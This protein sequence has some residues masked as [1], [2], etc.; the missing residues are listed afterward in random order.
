MLEIAIMIEGQN[1]LTWSRWQKIVHLVEELG[2]RFVSFD[3]FT[4]S[5]ANDL[6]SLNCGPRLNLV[7]R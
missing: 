7:G 6:Q 5:N 1:G 3:H 4:N 2:C